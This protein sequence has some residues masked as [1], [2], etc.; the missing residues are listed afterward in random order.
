MDE[1]ETS[2]DYHD[3]IGRA[4][5]VPAFNTRYAWHVGSQG[6]EVS[7]HVDDHKKLGTHILY[8]NSSDDWNPEWGGATL[9][10]GGKRSQ[11]MNPDFGGLQN[12]RRGAHRG[13]PQL[14]VQEYSQCVARRDRAHLS[15]RQLPPPLQHHL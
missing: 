4:L 2:E 6:S 15:A 12:P 3:F 5:G 10:L 11:A 1:L 14:P 9:V 8:F 13:Q 7:P